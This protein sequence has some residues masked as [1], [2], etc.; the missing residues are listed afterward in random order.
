[1]SDGIIVRVL[2]DY[3]PF[4]RIGKSIGYQ[5]TIGNSSFLVD[6]G[7]PLFQQIGGHGLKCIRGLLITHCHDDHKRWFSDLALFNMY[8]PDIA[9]KVTLFTSEDINEGLRSGSAS[10]LN[11]SLSVDSRRIV[12]IGYDDY[13]DF[14]IIGPR[15]KYRIASKSTGEGCS[16]I[17]VADREGNPVGPERAKI[18]ISSRSGQPRLLFRDPD[19]REWVEPDSYYDFSS[20]VFYESE[21]NIYRDAEGFTIEAIKA[22]VWHGVPSIGLKFSTSEETLVFSADTA[23]D[24]EL[25]R[26]LY[27]EKRVPEH[28]L[29]SREFQSAGIIHGDINDYIERTWS[30]ERYHAAIHAFADAAV[31]HDISAQKSVVHTD[32]SSLDRTV[33][34]KGRTIFTHSPDRMT[35]EWALSKAGKYFK[36]KDNRFMELV[37]DTLYPLAGDIFHKEQGRYY[38]GFK[39]P[40]GDTG[41]YGNNGLLSI[42]WD[43]NPNKGDLLYR[44]DLYEDIAGGY[45]PRLNQDVSEYRERSDGRVEEVAFSRDGSRGQVVQSCRDRLVDARPAGS[46][47]TA[48]TTKT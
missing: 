23:H 44:V 43:G 45:Y 30:E 22:P 32:Y 12:D 27:T 48:G 10:A 47:A 38:V 4:S 5:V 42:E 9:N 39:N 29:V 41:V 21:Q 11:T 14:S 40:D 20:S 26:R 31:I 46:P 2:G 15:A 33:L 6:C 3:G 28:S 24:I 19:S 25:W 37:G 35:S 18:V 1:M 13:I 34:H 17:Y 8:A 7:S 36:I 16:R